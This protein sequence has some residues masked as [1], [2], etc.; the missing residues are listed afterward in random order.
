MF[1][2]NK[3]PQPNPGPVEDI[4]GGSDVAGKAAP[5][6]SPN[7]VATQPGLPSNPAI[8]PKLPV[9]PEVPQSEEIDLGP[10]VAHF[11]MAK[12]AFI[13][14]LVLALI[15]VAGYAAWRIMGQ[16][17]SDDGVVQ[18]IP[19]NDETDSEGEEENDAPAVVD[20]ADEEEDDEEEGSSFFDT[21]GD[22]LTNSEELEAGTMANRADTDKDGL[23]DREEVKVYDTDPLEEDTDDDG[24][25]DGQE[26]K[27]GYNPNG[28]GKLFEVPSS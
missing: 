6:A 13:V 24:Y 27:G 3:L 8:S 7:P 9:S 17:P 5:A 18:S 16:S 2:D 11:G 4:F 22:G 15:A 12:V 23:G 26:V 20:A 19:G 28:E 21:D 25:L 10:R 14:A 1:D